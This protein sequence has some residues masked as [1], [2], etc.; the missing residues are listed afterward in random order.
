MAR[1][2]RGRTQRRRGGG[3][4]WIVLFLLIAG[5]LGVY[6]L[7]PD[8]LD[9]L[10]GTS[11]PDE[12]GDA[13]KQTVQTEGEAR[14]RE[15]RQDL[16]TRKLDAGELAGGSQQVDRSTPEDAAGRRQSQNVQQDDKQASEMLARAQD[17]YRSYEWDLARKQA[18]RVLMLQA[19]DQLRNQ[20]EDLL[21]R[22][23]TLHELFEKLNIKDELQRNFETHPQ[24]V[25]ISNRGRD[26]H[27]LPVIGLH[28]KQVPQTDDPVGWIQDQ[29]A[30]QGKVTVISTSGIT[31][32]LSSGELADIRA[33]DHDA[34][35]AERQRDF[36]ARLARL[37]SSDRA[38]DPLAWY[39]AAKFAYQNRLD[40]TD[41][42][43]IVAYIQA[44]ND[45]TIA[46]GD[47]DISTP[48]PVPETE[49]LW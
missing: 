32:S 40:A 33:A 27:V 41:A 45:G 12:L 6:I 11:A 15:E 34:I 23:E 4:G 18:R 17:S 28:D 22:A 36:Q 5:A 2:Q 3:G 20:A 25:T 10:I 35:I 30:S 16:P 42:A 8:L 46:E 14:E 13:P 24:L 19:S 29:L 1:Q 43:A 31:T 21:D 26:E 9:S 47:P 39:E 7:K 49:T 48:L 37:K 38:K 44:L